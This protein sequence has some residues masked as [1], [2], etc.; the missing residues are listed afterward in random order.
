VEFA[1]ADITCIE[2]NPEP[3]KQLVIEEEKKK[4]LQALATHHTRGHDHTFDDFV[5]GKGRGLVILL[6]YGFMLK[7]CSD[8]ETLT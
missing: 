3:F 1:V 2:W 8:Q 5:P 4:A 7:F 6:Q